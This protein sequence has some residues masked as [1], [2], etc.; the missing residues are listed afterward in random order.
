MGGSKSAAAI[1][2]VNDEPAAKA[3]ASSNMDDLLGFGFGNTKSAAPLQS[4]SSTS[5]DDLLGGTL[6]PSPVSA[7]P[8]VSA[9]ATVSSDQSKVEL[10]TF[11]LLRGVLGGGL[12][13]DY[14]FLRRASLHGSDT[15]VI[16]L[17]F[18]NTSDRAINNIRCTS[19]NPDIHAFD[20]IPVLMARSL[21]QQTMNI[22]FT[23]MTAEAS[24]G[25]SHEMGSYTVSIKPPVGELMCGR[26]MSDGEFE[27]LRKSLGGLNESSCSLSVT[28]SDIPAE[29]LRCANLALLSSADGEYRFGGTVMT[30]GDAVL[31]T[32]TS[33][34]LRVNAENALLCSMLIKQLQDVLES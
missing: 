9:T 19:N 18:R 3:D 33:S 8:V 16:Q 2:P 24:F 6:T 29:V 13:I 31:V 23:S 22:K 15:N 5:L 26:A 10:P 12:Q 17:S 4:S 14:Q 20:T 28:A 32:V 1:Q 11:E 27:S 7:Q 21:Y 25:I 30:S 34:S